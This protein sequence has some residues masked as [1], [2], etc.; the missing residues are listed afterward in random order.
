M[1][2]YS[3]YKKVKRK[4]ETSPMKETYLPA[5][6]EPILMNKMGLRSKNRAV[7]AKF[8]GQM[9]AMPELEAAANAVHRK[10]EFAKK[11]MKLPTV[12]V[13]KN[14]LKLDSTIKDRVYSPYLTCYS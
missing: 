8:L 3:V 2:R 1:D 10:S 4:G 11:L 5:D 6:R 7:F 13:P 12:K 14:K 9:R